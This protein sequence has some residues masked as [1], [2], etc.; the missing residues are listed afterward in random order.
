LERGFYTKDGVTYDRRGEVEEGETKPR[1]ELTD[2]EALA[3][4]QEEKDYNNWLKLQDE[5]NSESSSEAGIAE[6]ATPSGSGES[7]KLQKQGKSEV[8]SDLP[9]QIRLNELFEKL[10]EITLDGPDESNAVT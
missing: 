9:L 7:P 10:P 6:S 1:R 8:K 4:L 2:E 3:S 5:R